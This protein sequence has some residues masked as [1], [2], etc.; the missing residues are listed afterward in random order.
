MSLEIIARQLPEDYVSDQQALADLDFIVTLG[1]ELFG[2]L[3]NTGSKLEYAEE[4]ILPHLNDPDTYYMIA[5]KDKKPVGY[6]IY[7]RITEDGDREYYT[8]CLTKS[9]VNIIFAEPS[10]CITDLGVTAEERRNGVGRE[11]MKYALEQ[12]KALG[13]KQ[14]YA[15][16]WKGEQGQS[17]SLVKNVGFVELVSQKYDNSDHGVIVMKN[18]N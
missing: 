1:F 13:G 12:I 16:C 3:A 11:L 15:T 10:F 18:I 17:L 5:L 4:V 14:V 7:Q 2:T 9:E 6:C 8:D